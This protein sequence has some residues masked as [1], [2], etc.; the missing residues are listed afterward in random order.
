MIQAIK[1]LRGEELALCKC[2]ECAAE[3][4]LKAQHGTTNGGRGHW[5]K[6]LSIQNE[7][8]VHKKLQGAGWQVTRGKVFCKTCIEKRKHHSDPVMSSITEIRQPTR[9]QKREIIALLEIAYDTA[10]ERYKGTDNDMTVAASLQGV[11]PGWVAAIREE[12]FGA[13]GANDDIATLADEI[14]AF[15]DA[16]KQIEAS[17]RIDSNAISDALAKVI[18]S[19]NEAQ[20]YLKRLEAIKTA[21]GPKASRA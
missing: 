21:F 10:A 13:N 19:S 14:K 7:G 9:E 11:M 8:A 18:K 12:L 16:N 20:E 4:S 2:D 17:L 3:L 5:Q 6:T 15:I 1:G